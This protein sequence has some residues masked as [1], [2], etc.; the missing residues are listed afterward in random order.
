MNLFEDDKIR[1]SSGGE[2]RMK[3]KVFLSHSSKDMYLHNHFKDLLINGF[4]LHKD[5]IFSTSSA[6]S[7]QTGEVFSDKIKDALLSSQ[8]AILFI[9]SS[10]MRSAFCLSELGAAWIFGKHVIPILFDPVTENT[11]NTTPLQ[12]V[13]FRKL[14]DHGL[15]EIYDELCDKGV[16]KQQ[17]TNDFMASKKVFFSRI[18]YLENQGM[19]YY[20][21]TIMRDRQNDQVNMPEGKRCYLL[22]GLIQ[23]KEPAVEGETHWIFYDHSLHGDLSIGDVIKFKLDKVD[24]L[25]KRPWAD[26]LNNTRN[27]YPAR[28]K[29]QVI[30]RHII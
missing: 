19:D 12:G 17:S 4:G 24:E 21:A 29:I 8:I 16:I 14:S 22:S 11:Y 13:Q 26:G 5:E 20:T 30:N 23:G 9:S 18:M 1:C 7:L 28:E 6:R 2:D 3:L 25:N 27:V 10:Y 15:T